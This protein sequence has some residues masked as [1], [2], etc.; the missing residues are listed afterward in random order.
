MF[1]I[2]G[3]G[4]WGVGEGL[5]IGVGSRPDIR[6]GEGEEL[7]RVKKKKLLRGAWCVCA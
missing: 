6:F 3:F 5:G 2:V 4:V 7:L 1:V